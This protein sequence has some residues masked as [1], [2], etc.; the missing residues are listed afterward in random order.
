M[1]IKDSVYGSVTLNEPVLIDLIESQAMQRLSLVLQHGITALIGISFPVTRLDHSIGV[2][3]LT[4]RLG[5]GLQEQIA[6]LLHDVSHT[7]FSHVIDH[8]IGDPNRQSYHDEHKASFVRT[9]DLPAILAKHGFDWHDFLDETQYPILEQEAPAL[10]ADRVDYFLRD[11]LY[12]NLLSSS[13]IDVILAALVVHDGRIMVNDLAAANLLATQFMAADDASWSNFREVGL[14][15]L[16][17]QAIRQAMAI[18]VFTEDDIW[19]TDQVV[20]DK[21]FSA[22]NQPLRDTMVLISAE[23][24]FITDTETPD[25]TVRPKIRTIDPD[26]V[27]AGKAAP[28]STRVP[29]FAAKRNAYLKRKQFVWQMSVKRI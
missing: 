25:F 19:S 17:A 24:Q 28:L 14:Y 9:T 16:T 11:A 8:A 5:A 4:R 15:E 1:I 6:A 27:I 29:A 12:L 26:V 22:E 7:A 21:M 20:W 10:C 2:M 23:T 3:L 18:G 13:D